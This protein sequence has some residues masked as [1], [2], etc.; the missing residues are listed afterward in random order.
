M[1]WVRPRHCQDSA[2]PR[3]DTMNWSS[4]R[5]G[6]LAPYPLIPL[7][8]IPWMKR[9]WAMKNITI[10]GMTDRTVMAMVHSKCPSS[11]VCNQAQPNGDSHPLR[12]VQVGER[13]EEVVPPVHE[14]VDAY[15]T[16]HRT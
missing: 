13:S 10:R 15:H 5:Q 1:P 4:N 12:S 3:C 7:M 6:G 8:T 16:Q 11:C 14:F 9:R 2:G